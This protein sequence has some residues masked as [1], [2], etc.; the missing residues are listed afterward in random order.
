MSGHSTQATAPTDL[1]PDLQRLLADLADSDQRAS[2]MVQ[3]LSDRQVNWRPSNTEWSIAQCL[4]HLGKSNRIY[5]AALQRAIEESRQE[6]APTPIALQPGVFGR[7]FIR[8]LEPPPTRK[9]RAPRKIIPCE[10]ID[11]DEALRNFLE[12]DEAIRAVIRNGGALDLNRIR[13]KNPLFWF[14]RFTVATGLLIIAAHNRRHLWQAQATL[15]NPL[16]PK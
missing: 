8:T 1:S 9:L 10:R 12:S 2:E 11:K 16:F 7:M 4:D 15:E 5:A 14:L 3:A 6:P 13:F